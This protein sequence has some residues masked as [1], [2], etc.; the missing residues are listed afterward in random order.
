MR[1]DAS[2]CVNPAGDKMHLSSYDP[3]VSYLS[4]YEASGIERCTKAHPSA[5]R[6]IKMHLDASRRIKM[7]QDAIRGAI[8]K[9]NRQCGMAISSGLSFKAVRLKL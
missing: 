8:Y 4:S 9:A 2:R 1:Q 3:W 5:S 7:H 6:R